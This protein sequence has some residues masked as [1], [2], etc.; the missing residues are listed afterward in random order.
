MVRIALC[1][2][3]AEKWAIFGALEEQRDH[4]RSPYRETVALLVKALSLPPAVAAEFEAAA[5][6]P[7]RPRAR[8][9]QGHE[10]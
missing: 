4:R 10:H 2:G 9:D 1:H 3:L 8:P 5:A 6:R 7:Q